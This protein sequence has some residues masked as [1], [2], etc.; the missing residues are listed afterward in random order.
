MKLVSTQK[1]SLT[2]ESAKFV[3]AAKMQKGGAT[4]KAELS[5]AKVMTAPQKKEDRQ[6]AQQGRERLEEGS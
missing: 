2:Q 6:G 1:R 4:S 3:K 5:H